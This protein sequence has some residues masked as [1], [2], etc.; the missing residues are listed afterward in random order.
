MTPRR[1][2]ILIIVLAVLLIFVIIAAI[3]L[4]RNAASTTDTRPGTSDSLAPTP[5]QEAAIAAIQNPLILEPETISEGRVAATHIAELFAQRYGS[6]SNQGDY[7]NLRDLLPVM[8]ASYRAETETFLATA[9]TPV[10]QAFEGVTSLKL[11]TQVRSY[12]EKTGTAVVAVTLQQEKTSGKTTM[13][14]YRTLRLELERVGEDWRVDAV[15]WD[16]ELTPAG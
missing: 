10:G 8:T 2:A 6:Y 12:D 5:E 7:Q 14:G 4:I 9:A 3:V 16:N 15:R 11:S 13:V 1:R